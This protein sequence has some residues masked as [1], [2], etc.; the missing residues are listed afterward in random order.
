MSEPDLPRPS[1]S[2]R[3]GNVAFSVLVKL[4]ARM[5]YARR[6]AFAGRVAA[7]LIAPLAG[8]RKRIRENLALACPDLPAAEVERLVHAVPDNVGRS[9]AEIYSGPQFIDRI[10]DLPL[11]GPGAALLEQLKAEGRSAILVAAHYGNYDAWRGALAARGYRIGALYRPMNNRAF[12]D[13][14]VAAISRIAAPLFAR[15]KRGMGQMLRFLREGGM[16]ALGIDQYFRNGADLTFF[17]RT[18]RTPLSAAELAL[19]YDLPMIP[20]FATRQPDGLSFVIEVEE[21]IAPG[22]AEEMS[23]RF[24]DLLEAKVRA[25]M[26]Q[27]FW[28]HRRWKQR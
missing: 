11:T 17:G 22:S 14:Y 23:Q 28:I 19:K 16:L 24:N 21:P 5:P 7:G 12:N 27:W 18:A 9:L 13:R 15:D 26:D 8:W 6:V 3:L 1:L 4:A 20:I 25:H 10:R 2:D